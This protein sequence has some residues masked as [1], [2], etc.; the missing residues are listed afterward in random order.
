[1]INTLGIVLSY[2]IMRDIQPITLL[3]VTRLR[4]AKFT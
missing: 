4:T 3:G 1:M 2:A